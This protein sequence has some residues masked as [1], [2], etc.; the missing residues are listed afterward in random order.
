MAKTL[1]TGT[2]LAIAASYGVAKSFSSLSNAAEAVASFAADPSIAVGDVFEVTSGWGRLNNRL[3]RAKTV[4][5]TGPYLV[6]FEGIDTSDTN[7]YPAGSGVGSVREVLT[8]TALSQ[9]KEA[10]I[11]GGDQQFT[12]VSDMEDVTSKEMPTVRSVQ[13]MK[14]TAY[15]DPTL[16][17]Y[18][19]VQAA[20][21]SSVVT[22]LRVTF[23]NGAKMYGN[24][25]WSIM[26]MPNIQKN[27]A[28]EIGMDL[29]FAAQTTRYA[30]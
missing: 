24:A 19:P 3:V 10:T 16:A 23:K 27:S 5:G 28:L 20:N 25:Y 12:D 18:V 2:Q 14:I 22:G 30:T 11:S 1:S 29:S 13:K 8:W 15:D 9:I 7:V 21:D 26:P 4:T 17:W 6:T